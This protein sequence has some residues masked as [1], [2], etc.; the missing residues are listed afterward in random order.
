MLLPQV[1]PAVVGTG[2]LRDLTQPHGDTDCC[3]CDSD[4][5]SKLRAFTPTIL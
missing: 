5:S 4:V 2:G 1:L 3:Y